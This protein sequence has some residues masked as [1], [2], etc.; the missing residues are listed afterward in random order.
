MRRIQTAVLI[1][2]VA[3]PAFAQAPA[4]AVT[5]APALAAPAPTPLANLTY[6]EDFFPDATYDPRVPPPES[7]LGFPVGQRPVTHGQIEAVL[8]AIAAA[9]PRCKLFEYGKTHEGRT[10]Y[11]MV[12]AS[13]ANL[14]RLPSL[15]TG[16]ATLG[17]P[18]Q[19][20]AGEAER[21]ASSL[22][23]LA[24]MAYCI[25]G[26][27]MSG[28]DASLSVLY[29][30]AASTDA[31][32]AS[33]LENL[34]VII[35]PLM[36]P[37]GRD[38]YLSMLAQNRTVQPSVD[39][40]S[41]L[42]NGFWP[43]GRM[44]HYLFDLNRDWIFATQPETRG[45]LLA[46]NQWNPQ[47]FMESHEMGSQ[48]TFL[49]MPGREAINP[50]MPENVRKWEVKF[51]E[52]LA[53]AFDA[54]GWR[55]Y[56]GEW[57]DNWY[58]GYSSSWA[59][60]RGAV[61]N[62]YEQ[63]SISTDAVRRPEGTLHT[64]REAVHK[65]LT[66]SM[67]N[68]S[69]LSKNRQ[70]VL[71][72][73]VTEKRKCTGGTAAIPAR[74]F[75]IPPSKNASRQA[76]FLD[77]LH[78]QNFEVLRAEKA[79]RAGGKDRLGRD[80]RDREFPAGTLLVPARQPL[81]RLL[82]AMLEFDPR[83][84]DAFLTDERRDL[85]RFGESR[86]YDT[87]GFSLPML[88][89]VEAYT[90]DGGAPAAAGA[91]PAVPTAAPEP[92]ANT[93][94]TVAFVIDG[95][96]DLSVAAAGR[97][98]ERGVWVR[99]ADKAFQFDGRDFPVGSVVITRKDNTS[100]AGDLAAVVRDVCAELGLAALGVRTGWGPGDLPDLGGH[101]FVLLHAPRIAIVGRDPI[102]PYGYGEAWHLVDHVLGLRASYLDARDIGNFDLRRYNV[103]VVPEGASGI[104]GGAMESLRNW[105][106]AGGTLIAVGS[107]AGAFAKEK[108]GIGDTRQ[109]ADVLAKMDDYQQAIVREWE[110]RQTAPDP[111]QTWAFGPP[112]DVVFPWLIGEGGGKPSEDE[113]KRQD[114]WS[115]IFMP[116]GALVAG[117]VDDRSWLTGGC[118]EYVPVI[119]SGGTV[120]LS[121]PTV[122]TPVRLGY[123]SP[124]A[125]GAAVKKTAKSA[126][127][128][129]D[130]KDG[131]DAATAPGWTIAPP[132][133]E[134]RLRMS[135][136]LWP[137]AARRLANAAYVTREGIGNGQLILFASNP[138]FRAAALGTTRILANAIVCGPGMGASQPIQP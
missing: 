45:R 101:H 2:L 108:D 17:D 35:D 58:P 100:F 116:A 31:A 87:T 130:G 53:A 21:L 43:S 44:N 38:R 28:S 125:A 33:L 54:R 111:K 92:V 138:T 19:G 39:D 118:A 55:Y 47:Y 8:K 70:G 13:E 88:F 134:M 77:A 3:G 122:Q 123:F 68:L 121:P 71:G 96:D 117:R 127:D 120:L 103:I 76:R 113:L 109:L 26:D 74:T 81:A 52:D 29:Y 51:G 133:Y 49:F 18:R 42:H 91:K 112:E 5:S 80:V 107:S 41:L 61:E 104:L 30:L 106:K 110:G 11:Y 97:L 60:L 36:N 137:E 65:Q 132:G 7:I 23:A 86:I 12:I 93:Q 6:A 99:A 75:A 32:A 20:G 82:A 4:G 9:S 102:R 136:L 57:N 135:G 69:F 46:I 64:Y 37:D 119:Y 14:A 90:L 95:S 59:A 40:Q 1:L 79:F 131:K 94:T 15:Q 50:N 105:V 128:N 78:V 27:E 62:L 124:Q 24:W 66:A 73:F 22:P 10:L 16:W 63:A 126:K 83:M 114:A 85:L 72:D 98:M 25:H 89:D 84:P 34:V 67:A 129:K 115:S 56:T 48:D